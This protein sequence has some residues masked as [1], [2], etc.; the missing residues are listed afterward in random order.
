MAIWAHE[1]RT[2]TEHPQAERQIARLQEMV[3]ELR[4]ALMGV[5]ERELPGDSLPCFCVNYERGVHD[6]WCEIARIALLD[7]VDAVPETVH[8]VESSTSPVLLPKRHTGS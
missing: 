6:E 8:H 2:K 4:E 5:S 1:V 3:N 7:T